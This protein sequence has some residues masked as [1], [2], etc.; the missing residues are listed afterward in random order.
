MGNQKTKYQTKTRNHQELEFLFI[1]SLKVSNYIALKY[2]K[3]VKIDT[4]PEKLHTSP[5]TVRHFSKVAFVITF[6]ES[7]SLRR[8]NLSRL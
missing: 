5:I 8:Q 4:L 7:D 1:L 3:R 6:L 2:I